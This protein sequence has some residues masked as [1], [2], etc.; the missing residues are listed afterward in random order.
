MVGFRVSHGVLSMPSKYKEC[1]RVLSKAKGRHQNY[2][3][4]S[5]DFLQRMTN[6]GWQGFVAQLHP[7]YMLGYRSPRMLTSSCC[8]Q[9]PFMSFCKP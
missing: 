6:V 8:F 5:G 2:S 9:Y 1:S 4:A 7:Y 3:V